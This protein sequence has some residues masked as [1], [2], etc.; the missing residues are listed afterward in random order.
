MV[1]TKLNT[2][3]INDDRTINKT[4]ITY[5]VV[6]NY[7]DAPMKLIITGVVFEIPAFDSVANH[8]RGFEIMAGDGTCSDIEFSLE[9]EKL[10]TGKAVLIYKNLLIKNC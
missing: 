2:E 7:G 1:R 5:M 10:R 4:D 6:Y 3:Q 8:A 9:F